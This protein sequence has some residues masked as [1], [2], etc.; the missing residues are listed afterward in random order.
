MNLYEINSQMKG[1]ID[2]ICEAE[3]ELTPEMEA[4][5]EACTLSHQEK[6]ESYNKV[7]HNKQATIDIAET[8]AQRF[9]AEADRIRAL[10]KTREKEIET[11]KLRVKEDMESI[12]EK[13][14]DFTTGGFTVKK[15]SQFVEIID[16]NIISPLYITYE[17]VVKI[18]K[19]DIG[20]D[21][22]SGIKVKGAV[23]QTNP[24]TLTVR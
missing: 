8:E 3:G 18:S 10:N 11:L 20:A 21:L 7:I 13:R 24:T 17:E 5:L 14:I 19:T 22:R 2:K 1:I 9:D 23:L 12:D 16:A 4:E 6:L 15:G